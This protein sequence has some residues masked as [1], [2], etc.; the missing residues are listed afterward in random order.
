MDRSKI[1]A[2]L[3]LFTLGPLSLGAEAIVPW[4]DYSPRRLFPKAI[5]PEAIIP[6]AIVQE[7]IVPEANRPEAICPRATI[8][9]ISMFNHQSFM[10]LPGMFFYIKKRFS[11]Q[12]DARRQDTAV[13]I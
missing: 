1:L 8:M 12:S 5:I 9:S 11:I 10:L 4:G 7:V 2:S 3:A 13:P 6:G